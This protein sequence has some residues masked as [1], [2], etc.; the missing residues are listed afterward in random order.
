M[1]KTFKNQTI[2]SAFSLTF[3]VPH[4]TSSIILNYTL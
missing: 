1:G 4:F 3:V 2:Y